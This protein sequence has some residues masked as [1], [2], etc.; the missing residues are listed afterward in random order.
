MEEIRQHNASDCFLDNIQARIYEFPPLGC[1]S[2]DASDHDDITSDTVQQIPPFTDDNNYCLQE[3]QMKLETHLAKMQQDQEDQERMV[4]EKKKAKAEQ[5][6]QRRFRRQA[7]R[8]RRKQM[9]LERMQQKHEKNLKEFSLRFNAPSSKTKLQ[10]ADESEGTIAIDKSMKI[11]SPEAKPENPKRL[12]NL[13][14]G[15]GY[16]HLFWPGYIDLTKEHGTST[17]K[18]GLFGLEVDGFLNNKDMFL[19]TQTELPGLCEQDTYMSEIEETIKDIPGM[20]F[21]GCDPDNGIFY[22]F[23]SRH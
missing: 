8:Q 15:N 6:E 10:S 17:V 4:A 19:A 16:G 9:R 20:Q 11:Y 13:V 18:I 14:I 3:N 23:R 5:R 22:T 12:R 7:D 2:S 21:R 1:S